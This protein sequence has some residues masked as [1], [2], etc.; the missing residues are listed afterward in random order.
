MTRLESGAIRLKKDWLS[1]EEVVGSALAHLDSRLGER[2]IRTLLPSD[3]PLV[4]GDALLLEQLLI[5]LLENALKYSPGE[6]DISA[7]AT[8]TELAVEVSD[9]GPGVAAGDTEVIFDKFQRRAT[10]QQ[11]VGLGLSICRGIVVAHGGTIRALNREGGGATFRFT[12]PLDLAPPPVPPSEP[13]QN[14][15]EPAA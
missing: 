5:N 7:S 14:P 13:P 3:L 9:R 6:I 11:G 15:E 10:E 8:P 1:L 2:P 4:P 12:L